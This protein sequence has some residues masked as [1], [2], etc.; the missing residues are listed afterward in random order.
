MKTLKIAGGKSLNGEVELVA[1]KNSIM[2]A[3]PASILTDD[4][5]VFHD[6][7][8]TSDVREMF[9]VLKALGAKVSYKNQGKDVTVKCDSV[10][11]SEIPLQ[12]GQK[13]RSTLLFMGPLLAKFG[14]VKTVPPGGC[15]LG[16]RQIDT[17]ILGFKSLGAKVK[18]D[19]FLSLEASKLKGSFIWQDEQ[20]VTPTENL[21]MAS[22]LSEG[23]T[24]IYN[25]ASEPHVQDLCNLLNS[26]GGNINGIGSNRL[27]IKGVKKLHGT[28]FTPLK[29]HLDAGSYIAAA[30]MTRGEI[31]IKDAPIE[32][33]GIILSMYDRLGIKVRIDGKKIIVPKEQ[34]PVIKDHIT[35]TMNKIEAAPWPLFPVD[36]LPVVLVLALKCKGSIIIR[37]NIYEAGLF[38]IE[39]LIKMKAKVFLSDPHRAVTFGPTTFYGTNVRCPDIIQAGMAIFLASLAAE[40][41]TI[42][43]HADVLERRYPDIQS[44]YNKLGAKIEKVNGKKT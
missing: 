15:R 3:I 6:I 2:P 32:H 16:V 18:V 43:Q 27:V 10:S 39:E 36:L 35:G 12:M 29:E 24:T 4:P 19:D 5:V 17:H 41:T 44:A 31:V 8:K 34:N 14:R 25:A 11:T 38:F 22:I 20:G 42:L 7:P 26:M 23:T 37:N 1:N 30:V 40:G 33:M 9:Q 28:E 13:I 21:I